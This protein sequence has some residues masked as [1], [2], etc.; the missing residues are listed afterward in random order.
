MRSASLLLAAVWLAAC[1]AEQPARGEPTF[2]DDVLA[3]AATYPT[4]GTHG[5]HWPKKG[6]WLGITRD[7]HY[8]GAL[9]AEGDPRARCHCSGLTFEVF[10]RAWQR[11]AERGDASARIRDWDAESLRRFQGQWFG[12]TGD[13]A[14]LHTALVSNALGRR[15]TDREEARPGDFVQLWRHSGSGHSAVFRGWERDGTGHITGIRYWSTQ[16]STNGIAVKTESFG[17]EGSTVKP[18]ELYVV[19]VTVP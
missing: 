10:L 7:L 19:R 2:N 13:R 14:T 16:G 11:R 9:F 6:S 17:T 8:D 3:I 15:V 5:Y 18:D 4:D 1:A 12:V